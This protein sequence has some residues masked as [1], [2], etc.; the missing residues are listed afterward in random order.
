MCIFFYVCES[1]SLVLIT[2]VLLHSSYP[3][4][5]LNICCIFLFSFFS[6]VNSV[7]LILELL[8]SLVDIHIYI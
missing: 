5:L 2:S 4:P 6:K 8:L 3:K 7:S 1:A